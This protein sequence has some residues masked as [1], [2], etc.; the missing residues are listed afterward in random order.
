MPLDLRLSPCFGCI[1]RRRWYVTV[2]LLKVLKQ[3]DASDH[4]VEHRMPQP[5]IE[6][7][8]RSL[9][10]VQCPA[11][12]YHHCSVCATASAALTWLEARSA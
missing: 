10:L 7:S 6:K 5:L 12:M 9:T 1:L 8:E 11:G 4:I 2:L 3:V